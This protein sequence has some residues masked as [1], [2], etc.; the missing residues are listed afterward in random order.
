MV[1][2]HPIHFLVH[3]PVERPEPRLDVG[4][5]LPELVREQGARQR[6]VRVPLAH[7]DV[8]LRHYRGGLHHRPGDLEVGRLLLELEL[9][10]GL[11]ESQVSEENAVHLQVVVLPAVDENVLVAES[12]ERL[13]HRGHL[14]DLRAGPDD[15]HDAPHGRVWNDRVALNIATSS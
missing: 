5:G 12:V 9:D 1:R 3:R 14:D 11:P 15:R 13:H 6:G 8:G 10:I 7:D 2:E 4:H